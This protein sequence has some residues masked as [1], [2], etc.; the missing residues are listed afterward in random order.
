MR[1]EK[2]K[3]KKKGGDGKREE[4]E[5]ETGTKQVGLETLCPLHL[6]KQRPLRDGED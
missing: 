5:G 2:K 1:E 4:M 3:E 6:G